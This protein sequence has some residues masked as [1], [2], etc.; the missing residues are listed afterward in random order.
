MIQPERNLG[1]A[2]GRGIGDTRRVERALGERWPVPKPYV[3]S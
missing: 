3:D 1:G 2:T